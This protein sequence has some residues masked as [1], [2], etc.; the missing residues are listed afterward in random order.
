MGTKKSA[1]ACWAIGLLIFQ[2]CSTAITYLANYP[3]A[4]FISLIFE[5]IPTIGAIVLIFYDHTYKAPIT[6][7][8]TLL[9]AWSIGLIWVQPTLSLIS[10]GVSGL[11][12]SYVFGMWVGSCVFI[13][14]ATVL[15]VKDGKAFVQNRTKPTETQQNQNN[16][17]AEKQ[18]DIASENNNPNQNEQDDK[19][20]E[21]IISE[22][23]KPEEKNSDWFSEGNIPKSVIVTILCFAG[24]VLLIGI[25]IGIIN[26]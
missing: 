7:S 18:L 6:G 5:C 15:L 19:V 24:V 11:L 13:I 12:D 14:I 2:M 17:E 16:N 21:K 9:R 20:D 25:I 1:R 8:F 23:D 10:W 4:Y 22:T 26:C 3:F